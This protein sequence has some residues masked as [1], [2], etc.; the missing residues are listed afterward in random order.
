MIKECYLK[1]SKSI[2]SNKKEKFDSCIT[3]SLLMT[4]SFDQQKQ[5]EKIKEKRNFDLFKT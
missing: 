4:L 5:I 1:Y 2:I 3:E